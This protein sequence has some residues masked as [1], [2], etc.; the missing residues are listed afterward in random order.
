MKRKLTVLIAL[1]AALTLAGCSQNTQGGAK[2]QEAQSKTSQVSKKSSSA[3][4]SVKTSSQKE[5]TK[6][7]A[8]D[9]DYKTTA[10]AIAVYAAQ[11]YGDT[12]QIAV[13]AAKQ[14]NLRRRYV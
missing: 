13:D 12:W 6:L 3:K 7:S 8:D 11:K 4:P 5:A 9:M 2:S 10:S 1:S 14:N